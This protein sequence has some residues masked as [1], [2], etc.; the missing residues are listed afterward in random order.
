[1]F[2]DITI[3]GAVHLEDFRIKTSWRNHPKRKKLVRRLGPEGLVALYDLWSFC[4]TDRTDGDL[5]DMSDEDIALA[6]DWHGEP[7][8]F[9]DTLLEL[10]LVEGGCTTGVSTIRTSLA[11]KA[12]PNRQ[13][14]QPT[15]GGPRQKTSWW[16][17]P[18]MLRACISIASSMNQHC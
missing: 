5:Q 8:L 16:M 10:G 1:L 12:A 13:N 3:E 9:I 6:A 11:T 7:E 18:A 17:L 4:A 14:M 15:F 2:S